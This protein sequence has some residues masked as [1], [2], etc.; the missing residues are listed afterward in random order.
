MYDLVRSFVVCLILCALI[1]TSCFGC[2]GSGRNLGCTFSESS[3]CGLEDF[4]NDD[5]TWEITQVDARD[6]RKAKRGPKGKHN[7]EN[8]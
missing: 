4:V 3:T 1:L 8:V 7:G 6:H 2:F 5:K